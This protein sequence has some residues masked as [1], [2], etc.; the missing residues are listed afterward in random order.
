MQPLNVAMSAG[1]AWLYSQFATGVLPGYNYAGFATIDP[2]NPAAT[3]RMT[4]AFYFQRAIWTLDG[5]YSYGSLADDI[6][7]N[8]FLSLAAAHFGGGVAGLAVAMLPNPPGGSGVGALNLNVINPDLSTGA[9][10]QPMLMLLAQAPPP[11][12]QTNHI[13]RGDT[14]TIGFWHNKNGQALINA[15]PN[16]PALGNWLASSFPCLYGNLAGKSDS[17]IAAQF[18]TYFNVT[19]TKTKAQVLGAALACY[20]TSS[21]LS[22][23][24]IAGKYGFNLSP[25]GT[26]GKTYNVG[27]L[28]TVLGLSNNT[29][30]TVLQLLQAAN[31]NCPWSPAVFNALNV[32]FDGINESGDII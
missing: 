22:G 19:G 8:P 16:S 14:A 29:D 25:G 12:P 17:Q 24:T 13:G 6:T 27:S 31:A 11:P 3:L 23:T 30:Y 4:S 28:G 5:T 7:F 21:T 10:V 9:F 32:I 1:S 18:L 15:M 2:G 20:V 26:G